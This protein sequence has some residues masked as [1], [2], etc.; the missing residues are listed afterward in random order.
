MALWFDFWG[1]E[2]KNVFPFGRVAR[3]FNFSKGGFPI[4]TDA[5]KMRVDGAPKIFWPLSSHITKKICACGADRRRSDKNFKLSTSFNAFFSQFFV[6]FHISE[7]PL[8][9]TPCL[10]TVPALNT[11]E[12]EGAHSLPKEERAIKASHSLL[13]HPRL[14]P[15]IY[16]LPTCFQTQNILILRSLC[17]V[18]NSCL[19]L[20]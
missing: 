5:K 2:V 10:L 16:C 7:S 19:S 6:F 13:L 9:H 8:P 20:Q 15:L 12:G 3:N 1:E 11:W 17:N 4:F 18:N 14:R